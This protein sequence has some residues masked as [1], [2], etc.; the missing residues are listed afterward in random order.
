MRT[1]KA[2][3]V[4]AVIIIAFS[5]V[6][7]LFVMCMVW[8]VSGARLDVFELSII[9]RFS[10]FVCIAALCILRLADCVG[11]SIMYRRIAHIMETDG[12]TLQLYAM[13][14]N[15]A[16][17]ARGAKA[18]ATALL[19]FASYL[20]EGG[21]YKECYEILEK[22]SLENLSPFYQDEYFNVYLYAR[23]LDGDMDGAGEIYEKASSNFERARLREYNMPVLH[24]LGVYEYAK[25][26]YTQAEAL[27]LQAKNS[28][29]T[30]QAKADCSLYLGLCYLKTGRKEYAKAAALEAAGQVKTVYQKNNLKKLMKL[31]EKAYA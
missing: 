3:V 14:K 9:Y 10:V 11:K 17:N 22:I 19:T 5:F 18:K 30:K 31:V 1:L 4:S 12:A 24:T 16:D 6:C 8:L 13:L 27:L 23:L 29:P 15:Q 21:H 7:G 26:N 28:A 25:G 2:A 20:T